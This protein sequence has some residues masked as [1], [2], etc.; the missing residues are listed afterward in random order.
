MC[1]L[2][3]TLLK[4]SPGAADFLM[5]STRLILSWVNNRGILIKCN[6]TAF[7]SPLEEKEINQELEYWLCRVFFR[8]LNEQSLSQQVD[9]SELCQMLLNCLFLLPVSFFFFEN[10]PSMDKRRK[11]KGLGEWIC[12]SA[13]LMMLMISGCT[14]YK[15]IFIWHVIVIH[16]KSSVNKSPVTTANEANNELTKI[17]SLKLN[18][19]TCRSC[20]WQAAH[21][22]PEAKCRKNNTL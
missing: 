4:I 3:F 6:P 13:M 12:S 21:V 20:K 17:Q 9:T 18:K 22:E 10:P 16:M 2:L 19:H 15:D 11:R 7:L 8:K 14:K 1:R 5:H